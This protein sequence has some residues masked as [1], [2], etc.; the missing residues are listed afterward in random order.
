MTPGLDL[1]IS[2]ELKR[3]YKSFCAKLGESMTKRITELMK[4]DMEE[5]KLKDKLD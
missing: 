3:E 1:N 5:N 2:E 4:R